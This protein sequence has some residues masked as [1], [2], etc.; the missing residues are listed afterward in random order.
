MTSV[1][2]QSSNSALSGL[3]GRSATTAAARMVKTSSAS[4]LP[5]PPAMT[6]RGE[7]SASASASASCSHRCVWGSSGGYQGV[8]TSRR[9]AV[10]SSGRIV[11]T[12]MKRSKP[13][14]PPKETQTVTA[15]PELSVSKAP[16]NKPRRRTLLARLKPT[17]LAPLRPTSRQNQ[18]PR[19][20]TAPRPS[21]TRRNAETVRAPVR[22]A[23][24]SRSDPYFGRLRKSKLNPGASHQSKVDK[25]YTLSQFKRCPNMAETLTG[26]RV[27]AMMG[28]RFPGGDEKYRG[29]KDG[30]GVPELNLLEIQF[31]QHNALPVLLNARL[32][33]V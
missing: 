31:M 3:N 11:V 10:E 1:L 33:E 4:G 12:S 16:Q 28:E 2:R 9:A 8:S 32:M 27:R 5:L 15:V 13:I 14:N 25:F 22:A 21:L 24:Y 18:K 17:L 23:V 20:P 29:I 6:R 19:A 30:L 26:V 7:L